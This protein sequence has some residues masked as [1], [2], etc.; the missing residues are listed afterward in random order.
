MATPSAATLCAV[1]AVLV[2]LPIGWLIARI[3]PLGPDLRLAATPILGWA[4]QCVVALQV[5][6]LAGFS[7]T[8][9]I[10]T[11]A[12]LAI[13]A[14]LLPPVSAEPR[15]RVLPPWTLVVAALVALGPAAAVLPKIVPDGIALASPIYDHTKIALIDE[16]VRAGVPPAN[17]F[18]GGG[19]PGRIAYYYFW[20]FGA[21]QLAIVTGAR[22]WEADIAATW[23]TAFATLSLM[24]GL[25]LHLSGGRRAAVVFVLIAAL[26]GS[27]RPLFSALLGSG[28]VGAIV[29]PASGFAGWLFQSSWS[30]HHVAAA[31][32]VIVAIVI[33]ERL[34]FRP[35][36]VLVLTFGFLAAAAFASSLWVGGVTFG[37][38][39]TAATAVLLARVDAPRRRRFLLAVA[40][41]AA[42]AVVLDL[43]LLL[44]QVR[45]AAA[46]GDV[47]PILVSPFPVL[48]ATL[49]E[50]ARRLLDLPAY[51]LILLPIEFPAVVVLGVMA[52]SRLKDVL[53]APLSAVALVSIAAAGLFVSTVGDN[54][55]LG[56]RAV[57][58]GLMIA[59]AFA[60]GCFAQA[61]E[62]RHRGTVIVGLLSLALAL[63]DGVALLRRNAVGETSADAARFAGAPVLWAAVRRHAAT[64]ERV[65]SNPH[66][67]G[68]LLPWDISLSW[69]LLA[70]RRSCFAG[71]ELTLTFAP[72][73]RAA[74]A[75][76][77][78]LFDRVF[79]GTADAGDIAALKNQF[80]C[81]VIVLT[82]EDGA[83]QHDPF[84]TDPSFT[85]VA[86]DSS[87]W[88]IYRARLE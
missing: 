24:C 7:A 18:L 14:A 71:N 22:G 10:S 8:I 13:A 36:P 47:T 31:A 9:V 43:P 34:A 38:G 62:R 75:R 46:R 77:S 42:I 81:R 40:V 21:A 4:V 12:T 44:E 84:A 55:D 78:D 76:A 1:I 19:E 54:N 68:R 51:W 64:N 79:A 69:A 28:T 48:A 82:P 6:T 11:T 56:W 59:I 20:L 63:P 58:P 57:L 60:G 49:P 5:A 87:K 30:P 66:M 39:A 35:G 37:L 3:L 45:A 86:D 70:D 72:I 33:M 52:T 15:A 23:F 27:L 25:A 2:W 85:R 80:D 50:S 17:P 65:A 74:R 88:R 29:E 67:T 26:A 32:T 41:A 83:W 16:M 73:S 61:L 53:V